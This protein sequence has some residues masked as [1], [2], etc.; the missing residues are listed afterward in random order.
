MVFWTTALGTLTIISM[1]D[2]KLIKN[3]KAKN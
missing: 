3:G 2:Q 1:L